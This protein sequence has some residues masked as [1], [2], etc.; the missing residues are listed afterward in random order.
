MEPSPALNASVLEAI[1]SVDLR[2]APPD[3]EVWNQLVRRMGDRDAQLVPSAFERTLPLLI[4]DSDRL[5]LATGIIVSFDLY[6]AMP[7][8]LNLARRLKSSELALAAA[9]FV[10]H[11]GVPETAARVAVTELPPS[12]EMSAAQLEAFNIRTSPSGS[13]SHARGSELLRAM[14]PGLNGSVPI[15]YVVEEGAPPRMQLLVLGLLRGMGIRVR[16]IPSHPEKIPPAVWFGTQGTVVTWTENTVSLLR[17]L[18]FSANAGQIILGPRTDKDLAA[19]TRRLETRFG[20]SFTV[21][22]ERQLLLEQSVLTPAALALG[23]F[24]IR[25]MAYLGGGKISTLYELASRDRLRPRYVAAGHRTG[26]WSFAQLIAF[27]TWRY[28]SVR[29]G[30]KTFPTR[31]VSEL[32][33]LATSIHVAQ[34]AVTADGRLLESDD[35]DAR[36]LMLDESS[37]SADSGAWHDRET[38]QRVI[39]QVLTIDRV[40]QP[41]ALGGGRVPNLVSPSRFT[42]VDPAISGGTPTLRTTRIAARAIAEV[43]R[44]QGRDAARDAYPEPTDEELADGLQVGLELL[45]RE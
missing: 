45:S 33:T 15:S 24:D 8:L 17:A 27:R 7:T 44:K 34:V 36:L 40:F 21:P 2:A 23:S 10:P 9:S 5:K 3:Y 29:A 22:E 25:D 12:V 28:F 16:R 4:G 19:F 20:R 43:V 37:A 35:P 13:A 14:W 31:L 6:E 38:G 41:F 39:K 18:G 32:E 1:V 30:T 42:R 26:L 11:P